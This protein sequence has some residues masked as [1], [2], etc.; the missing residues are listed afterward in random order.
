M[1]EEED[2][3]YPIIIMVLQ[4][5]RWHEVPGNDFK[6]SVTCAVVVGLLWWP[7]LHWVFQEIHFPQQNKVMQMCSLF[8]FSDLM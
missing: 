4:E 7:H 3:S 8:Y 2:D 6:L 1:L 5:S